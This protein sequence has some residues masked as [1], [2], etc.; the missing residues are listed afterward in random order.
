[1]DLRPYFAIDGKV[2]SYDGDDLAAALLELLLAS[3]QTSSAAGRRGI[4]SIGESVDEDLC[5]ARFPGCIRKRDHVCVV[6]VNTTVGDQSQQMKT[7]TSGAGEGF[8]QYS[9]A[10]QFALRDRLLNF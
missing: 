8:L 9:V 6:A 2:T 1:M 3:L 10:P 7:M 5:D 4:A